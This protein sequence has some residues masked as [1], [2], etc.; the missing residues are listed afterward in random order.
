VI[1]FLPGVALEQVVLQCQR[2]CARPTAQHDAA[3]RVTLDGDAVERERAQRGTALDHQAHGVVL[4]HPAR[5]R[6]RVNLRADQ[7]D[8]LIAVTGEV[9]VLDIVDDHPVGVGIG[10]GHHPALPEVVFARLG[11]DWGGG[12]LR[13]PVVPGPVD[14][15]SPFS[16]GLL[17]SRRSG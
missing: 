4:D 3:L 13:R 10:V 9:R 8:T 16:V 14:V 12:R 1:D 17:I 5:H 11:Q 7:V 2:G 15:L 6:E